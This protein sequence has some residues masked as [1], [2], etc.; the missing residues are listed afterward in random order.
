MY[1]DCDKSDSEV[2][3]QLWSDSVQDDDCIKVLDSVESEMQFQNDGISNLQ[4]VRHAEC[5]ELESQF[6][7]VPDSDVLH[8]VQ[9]IESRCVLQFFLGLCL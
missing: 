5:A 2:D 3:Q 9:I 1:D 8:N 4:L 7:D 6:D